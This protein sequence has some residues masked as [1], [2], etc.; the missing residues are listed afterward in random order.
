MEHR[1]TASLFVF[2]IYSW[3]RRCIKVAPLERPKVIRGRM[4]V[5]LS[6]VNEHTVAG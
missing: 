6:A 5:G 4:A 1:L 3:K 2:L